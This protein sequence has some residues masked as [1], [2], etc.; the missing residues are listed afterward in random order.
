MYTGG[1][2]VE[3]KKR[4]LISAVYYLTIAAIIF[5]ILKYAVFV[6]MPF[7]IGFTVA[8][9]LN[10][11]VRF[12]CRRFDMKRRPTAVL[13]L[14]LFYATIGM[15]AT[16]LVVR[17]TVLIGEFSGRLPYIWTET[18]E[19]ALVSGFNAVNGL[20]SKFDGHENSA[21]A[22]TLTG[23][24]NSA[25]NSLG[26]AVSDVSV[27]ALAWLSGFAAAVPRFVVE[28]LF[29][30]ISSF[31]FMIDYEGLLRLAKKR[32][33]VRVVGILTELRDKFFSTT[34]KYLRSYALIMLITFSE[35]LLGLIL[36]RTANAALLALIIALL[37][38]LPVIGTGAVVIPW[39][40]VEL[41]RGH[42]GYGVGLIVL[43]AVITVVRNIIEP[44]IV[45]RGVGLHPLATLISMFVGSK[46]F[47]FL[48]LILLPVGL[49]IAL[50]V[51]GERDQSSS[52]S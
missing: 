3:R 31:F 47:G 45:G 35:L 46:L 12:L 16:V 11:A 27:R 25:K 9:C 32:L 13:I 43:W 18:V 40:V 42:I 22:M 29:A 5:L 28:L 44:K 23:F 48:G 38:I 26:N 20:L 4:F 41:I 21:F 34:V 24:F 33:P 1:K 52:A 6:V 7:L 50:S 37:D 30:V 39:A 8:A 10:P 15:L 36:L 19:P 49:S 2:T 17:L 51:L 14:L